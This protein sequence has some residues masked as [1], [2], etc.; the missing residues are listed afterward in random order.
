LWFRLTRIGQTAFA[1]EELAALAG[2]TI[3]SLSIVYYPQARTPFSQHWAHGRLTRVGQVGYQVVV[4]QRPG[5][6]LEQLAKTTSLD[7]QVCMP[8]RTCTLVA[9]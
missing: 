8:R 3:T 1:K 5:V 9:V 4:P 2:S 6:T 7:Y